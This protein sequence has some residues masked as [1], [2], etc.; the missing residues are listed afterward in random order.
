M[1][2]FQMISLK[3]DLRCLRTVSPTLL[4]NRA[5]SSVH[6]EFGSQDNSVSRVNS[7]TPAYFH[8]TA[9]ASVNLMGLLFPS[10]FLPSLLL[11]CLPVFWNLI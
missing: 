11:Q 8:Y 4:I 3:S 6:V 5:V 7:F 9:Y 10:G 2:P 1:C